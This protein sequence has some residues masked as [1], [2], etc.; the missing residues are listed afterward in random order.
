MLSRVIIYHQLS[1]FNVKLQGQTNK[2]ANSKK[3]LPSVFT[4]YPNFDQ[5]NWPK[6][7]GKSKWINQRHFLRSTNSFIVKTTT[8][9]SWI[10]FHKQKKAPLLPQGLFN[11]NYKNCKL[12]AFYIKPCAS[13][14]TFTNVIW[15]IRSHITCQSK[16]LFSKMH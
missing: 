6:T 12:C 7:E 8:P 10:I 1:F 14:K 16:N 4:Y 13:F 11:C 15:C 3:I 9:Y 5:I 2:P